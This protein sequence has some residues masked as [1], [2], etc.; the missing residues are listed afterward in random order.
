[1]N[2]ILSHRKWIST[3]NE[4]QEEENPIL[5]K[6]DFRFSSFC[7]YGVLNSAKSSLFLLFYFI[8]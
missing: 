7:P 6:P 4:T 5:E 8:L 3:I 1:L 2:S